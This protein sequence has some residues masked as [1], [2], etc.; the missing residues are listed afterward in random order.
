M[1]FTKYLFFCIVFAHSFSQNA[2]NLLIRIFSQKKI[3]SIELEIIQGSYQ[4][5]SPDGFLTEVNKGQSIQLQVN[6]SGQIHV[7]KNGAFIGLYDTLFLFQSSHTDYISLSPDLLDKSHQH[8]RQYE[9]DFKCFVFQNH[10]QVLNSI[11]VESYLEGVLASEAGVRCEKEYY[12]VQAIISRTFARNNLNKHVDQ[13]YHLCDAVH[14]QAYY[15][16]YQGEFKGINQGVKETKGLVLVDSN[17]VS[18]PTFFSANCGGQS[19]ETD[20]IWSKSLPNYVSHEDTFCVHTRQANWELYISKKKLLNY[21]LTNYYFDISKQEQRD[22][23]FN[24][25]QNKRKTFFIHPSFGI[26]LRDLRSEFNLRSTFFS[27]QPVGDKVLLR[28][29]GFGHGIGLC[30]EGAMEMVRFG[31]SYKDILNFY[32]R[33][34]ELADWDRPINHW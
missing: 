23:V 21:L 30:Q 16:N 22:M 32:F 29:R 14:C 13:G 33:G 27:C 10:I 31:F 15:G 8:S 24:F 4:V 3:Q 12:K 5:Q 9:G 26:P 6:S 11:F 1:K 34:A 25:T 20:Q 19:A 7:V 17:N 18:F 28:G 2:Q